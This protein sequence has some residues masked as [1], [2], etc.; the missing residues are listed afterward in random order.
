M[1]EPIG[2]PIEIV[3]VYIYIYIYINQRYF[4]GVYGIKY[5]KSTIYVFT[6][7][8]LSKLSHRY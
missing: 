8:I 2:D 3:S 6:V 7:I 4:S 1:V 5:I